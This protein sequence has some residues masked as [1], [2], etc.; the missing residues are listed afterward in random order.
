MLDR[1]YPEYP[2]QKREHEEFI[3]RIC[4]FQKEFLKRRPVVL[5][6]LFNFVW[7]WFARHV[8]EMDKKYQAYFSAGG[9]G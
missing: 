7:D 4:E 2:E 8:L 3:D 1:C 9:T 5:I 6:N